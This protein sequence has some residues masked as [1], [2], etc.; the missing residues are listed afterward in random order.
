MS[1]KQEPE[2]LY[3]TADGYGWPVTLGRHYRRDGLAELSIMPGEYEG[4]DANLT[5]AQL[6]QLAASALAW[7]DYLDS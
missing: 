2:A 4:A 3:M 6:R 7:A 1:T 5:P